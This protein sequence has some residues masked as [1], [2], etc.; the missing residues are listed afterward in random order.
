MTRITAR[1]IS[2]SARCRD[3][4]AIQHGVTSVIYSVSHILI[5][6]I[7]MG[8]IGNAESPM[9]YKIEI[10]DEYSF[11]QWFSYHLRFATE[12]EAEEC[13]LH[14]TRAGWYGILDLRVVS[15]G[16]PVNARW[17]EKGLLDNEGQPIYRRPAAPTWEETQEEAK[18]LRRRWQRTVDR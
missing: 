9:S 2:V 10:M 1:G 5:D 8:T 18:K 16:E 7:K 12:A 13:S 14:F 11:G 6:S 17:T 3:P 4:S 15:S